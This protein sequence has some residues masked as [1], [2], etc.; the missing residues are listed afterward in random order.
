MR[1]Y[2]ECMVVHD[3]GMVWYVTMSLTR[4][5]PNFRRVSV[6][7]IFFRAIVQRVKALAS[8]EKEDA[9]CD[10]MD[11]LFLPSPALAH[12]RTQP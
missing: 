11:G 5:S 12:F 9:R 7:R 6:V 10:V 4:N 2:L 3:Y 8:Q 1:M